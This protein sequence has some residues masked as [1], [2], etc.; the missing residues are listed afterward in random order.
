M[1]IK[2]IIPETETVVITQA[3]GKQIIIHNTVKVDYSAIA[4]VY[5]DCSKVCADLAA[6]QDILKAQNYIKVKLFNDAIITAIEYIPAIRYDNLR[7]DNGK[8]L[9]QIYYIPRLNPT[10]IAYAVFGYWK[11][12]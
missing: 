5:I 2:N 7:L 9:T 10:R 8:L 11:E 3:D 6:I 4:E 1:L 12:V